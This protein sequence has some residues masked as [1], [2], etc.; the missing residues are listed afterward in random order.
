ML[1]KSRNV[2]KQRSRSWGRWSCS[3]L[4]VWLA[5]CV[6]R[7]FFEVR[8]SLKWMPQ[9]SKL[10]SGPCIRKPKI[11][12]SKIKLTLMGAFLWQGKWRL[13][14]IKQSAR[15]HT[16]KRQQRWEGGS[17]LHC[18]TLAPS[19]LLSITQSSVTHIQLRKHLTICHQLWALPAAIFLMCCPST[20]H[21]A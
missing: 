6:Y 10:Q 3:F 5:L 11:K 21:F 15:G 4:A 19:T 17:G 7:A 20:P 2:L 1:P 9:L 18:P 12:L 8:A 14:E 16:A 13:R